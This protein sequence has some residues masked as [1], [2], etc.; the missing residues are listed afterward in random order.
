MGKI[1]AGEFIYLF[2]N[3]PKYPNTPN[4]YNIGIEQDA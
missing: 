1:L 3:V 2:K 4:T